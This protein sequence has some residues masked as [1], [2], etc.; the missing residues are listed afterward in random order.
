[1]PVAGLYAT[2]PP[3]ADAAELPSASTPFCTEANCEPLIASVDVAEIT[4]GATL[5]IWRSLPA[6]PTETTD[7]AVPCAVPP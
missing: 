5:V 1:M 4:P 6:A 7:E 3:R 2:V